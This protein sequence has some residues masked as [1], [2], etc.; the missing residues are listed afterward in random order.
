MIKMSVFYPKTQ[1]SRFDIDYYCNQHIA[2]VREKLGAALKGVAVEHGLAGG[3]PGSP[4]LY[5]AMGHLYFDT[6]ESFL[7][8]FEPNAGAI[9]ADVPNYTNVEPIIQ[10]SEVK[11]K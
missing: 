9:V 4:P 10:I 1:N 8:A 7:N 6:V 3:T 2:L 11:L 5:A